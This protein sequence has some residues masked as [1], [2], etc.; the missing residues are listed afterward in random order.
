MYW[1]CTDTARLSDAD[2]TTMVHEYVKVIFRMGWAN[3]L[4][5]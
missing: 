1:C 3:A 2:E 4:K 5:C